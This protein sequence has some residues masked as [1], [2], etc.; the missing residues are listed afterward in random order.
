MKRLANLTLALVTAAC[1]WKSTPVVMLGPADD[2]SALAGEWSGEYRS[3]AAQRSGTIWFKLDAA[4]DTAFG[5]VLMIPRDR[6]MPPQPSAPEVWRDHTQVLTIKFVRVEGGQL[7]GAIDPYPSPEDGTLLLTVFRG[8]LKGDRVEGE[9]MILDS[10]NDRPPRQ[11]TWW[12]RRKP[13]T[14]SLGDHVSKELS[15]GRP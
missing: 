4:R 14:I 12:A 2:I 5:D 9:F 15:G 11:G 3:D 7:T 6:M 10:V 1:A 13:A 8:A